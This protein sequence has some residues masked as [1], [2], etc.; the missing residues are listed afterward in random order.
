VDTN[1]HYY[2]AIAA[3]PRRAAVRRSKL[4]II[5]ILMRADPE[6]VVIA[7]PLAGE[8]APAATDLSGVNAAF[9]AKA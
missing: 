1:R 7:L 3:C 6:P 8:S 9:L 4:K 2:A 5:V